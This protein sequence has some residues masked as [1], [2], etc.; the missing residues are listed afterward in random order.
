[1]KSKRKMRILKKM[2]F[3]KNI[4]KK[5]PI[6]ID[7]GKIGLIVDT[8]SAID[9]GVND[10]F[11]KKVVIHKNV[12]VRGNNIIWGKVIKEIPYTE[13]EV[14]SLIRI[15]KIPIVEKRL[16]KDF[17]FDYLHNYGDILN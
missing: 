4:F 12:K 9:S 16:S 13:E 5:K 2:R 3:L 14:K 10:K 8:D 1:M 6:A 11:N 7:L 17:K 15:L